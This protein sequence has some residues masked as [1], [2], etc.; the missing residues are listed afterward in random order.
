MK[1]LFILF[2]L[3]LAFAGLKA[4]TNYLPLGSWQYVDGRDTITMYFKPDRLVLGK[5]VYHTIIGFHESIKN[6]NVLETNLSYLNTSYIDGNYSVI[7]YNNGPDEI[8][9]NGKIKSNPIRTS[10]PI[11]KGKQY[12][13]LTFKNDSGT[14]RQKKSIQDILI[15][16]TCY[17]TLTKIDPNTMAIELYPYYDGKLLDGRLFQNT[18]PRSFKLT[19]LLTP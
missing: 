17:I 11:Y 2:F 16:F 12:L 3:L 14:N 7:I 15:P 19:R 8:K 5:E 10:G 6:G 9:H 13:L 18:L 4:Q 1:R